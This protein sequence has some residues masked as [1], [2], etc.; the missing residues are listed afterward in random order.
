MTLK[1]ICKERYKDLEKVVAFD[2]DGTLIDSS[3]RYNGCLNHWIKNSVREHIMN[4]SLLPL[5]D[6]YHLV[7]ESGVKVIAVTAR[8]MKPDDY[9]FLT[10]HGIVFDHILH[11]EDYV[12][13]DFALKDIRLSEFFSNFNYQPLVAFDDKP[14]NLKVFE[15]HGFKVYNA[16]DINKEFCCV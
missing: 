13:P 5:V 8:E 12:G 7:R 14:E 9:Y 10:Y 16:E 2:L 4:D 6:F 11:R 3:H 15:K 1:E